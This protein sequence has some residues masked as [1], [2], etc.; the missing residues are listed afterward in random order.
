M[1][2]DRWHEIESLYH[3]ALACPVDERRRFLDDACKSDAGL[4]QIIDSLLAR[5]A[6]TS[7][8]ESP[9]TA[10][11]ALPGARDTSKRAFERI[12]RYRIASLLGT[13]GMGEVY[14]AHDSRLGRDVA[15]KIL[16]ATLAQDPDRIKRLEREARL[17]AAFNHPHIAAI[18]ELEEYEGVRALVLELV[19]GVTLAQRIAA[20]PLAIPAALGIARQFA[21]A[22]RAAHSKG[23]IHRDFKPAN[24]K[25]TPEG[26]VK[27]LDFGLAKV[28]SPRAQGPDLSM[29][30]VSTAAGH[31]GLLI[32]TA[33]YMSPEQARGQS[34]D[35]RADIWAFGCVLFEMIT[36][37][38]PFATRSVLETLS[39]VLEREPDWRALPPDTP[40]WL[41]DLLQRCL[42]KDI[43]LR[44]PDIAIARREI[45]NWLESGK[46]PATSD[47]AR[48]VP[49]GGRWPLRRAGLAAALAVVVAAIS[50]TLFVKYSGRSSA[51]DAVVSTSV[52]FAQRDWLVIADLDNQTGEQ[53]FDKSLNTALA[54]SIGQSSHVN[55]VPSTRVQ[56]ALRRMRRAADTPITVAVAREIALR[57]GI[58]LVL[59]PSLTKVSGDYLLSASLVQPS[60]GAAMSTFSVP[61]QSTRSVLRGI[62]QLSNRIRLSLGE[63]TA[64]LEKQSKP[65]MSV[66]TS[67]LEAL[68]LYSAGAEK[69]TRDS[70]TAEARELYRA[71]LRADPSFTAAKAQLGILEFEFFDRATGKALLTE[72]VEHAAELTDGEKYSV[73]AFYATAV[74]N[75]PAKAAQSWKALLALYPDR[76]RA[77]HNL[78]RVYQQTWRLEEAVA[79]YREAIRLDPY[80][81]PSY[82]SLNSI[83]LYDI[84]DIASAIALAKQ[85]ISY[86][87]QNVFAYDRLGWANL[88]LGDLENARAAFE[89][90]IA[91]NPRLI[92]DRYRLGHTLRLQG[93]YREARQTFLKITEIAPAE[94][95]PYYHAGVVSKLMGESAEAR[96]FFERFRRRIEQTLAKNDSDVGERFDYAAVLVR[97]GLQE[98]GWA[99][100]QRALKAPRLAHSM[101]RSPIADFP[102]PPQPEMTSEAPDSYFDLARVLTLMGRQ[103][104][105]IAALQHAVDA[106]FR[107]YVWVKINDDLEAL[108]GVPQF[109]EL[110]KRGLNT[111]R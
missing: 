47:A 81:M 59:A 85:Q 11:I 71:A 46:A 10:E 8:R 6:E 75:D 79:E 60:D 82:F 44:L 3:D 12:G 56:D 76:A 52:P 42:Q 41:R 90:A 13:G 7:A 2:P 78:G 48:T 22:L 101:F 94:N 95:D 27:V 49:D 65:L 32:G 77:H 93:K 16:P 108:S 88:G 83:Y 33:A 23:I 45:E 21:D 25:I 36:G 35:A 107:N 61:A 53:I 84:G 111:G 34:L 63:A 66:T 20:G 64:G 31:D 18:Y 17:L 98:R 72:A 54:V 102:R 106:G 9:P 37:R 5:G 1:D 38:S 110:L 58:K 91:V 24:I 14:R 51:R 28:W 97:L 70:N 104:D 109:Q 30:N 89:K 69:F 103:T 50:A 80:F 87:D 26:V 99:E 105:A 74:E 62:D 67:S 92:L 100:A 57:D 96:T 55:I 4:R 73:I 19:E 15:V 86:N 43:E 68:K 29:S 40:A 39:R